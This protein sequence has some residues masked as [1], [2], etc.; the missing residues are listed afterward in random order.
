MCF[1]LFAIHIYLMSYHMFGHPSGPTDGFLRKL[2]SH[3]SHSNYSTVP[4]RLYIG[5]LTVN[6]R[7]VGTWGSL[8]EP[9][10]CMFQL[11]WAELYVG[12]PLW[13]DERWLILLSAALWP[14]ARIIPLCA[15][16]TASSEGLHKNG[17]SGNQTLISN[18]LKKYFSVLFI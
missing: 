5:M 2:M 3:H 16:F 12:P 14:S 8:S 1:V 18:P 4:S 11:I 17:L 9:H 7:N 15:S 13:P 10:S 6:T